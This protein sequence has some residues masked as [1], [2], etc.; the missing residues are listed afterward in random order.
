MAKEI[1]GRSKVDEKMACMVLHGSNNEDEEKK[2]IEFF[3][4]KVQVKQTRIDT[5]FDSG[6][7]ANLIAEEYVK[8]LALTTIPHPHP[9]P[10]GWVHKK[11]KL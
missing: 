7:Q 10:L 6:S 1:D 9:Y 5:L 2:K 11:S 4:I 3:H 8:S